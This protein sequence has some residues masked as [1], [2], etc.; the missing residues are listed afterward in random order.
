M[1]V[2]KKNNILKN[3][4]IFIFTKKSFLKCVVFKDSI[5]NI[6]NAVVVISQGTSKN[7]F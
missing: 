4:E 6:I 7:C 5:R 3:F 1:I 2:I